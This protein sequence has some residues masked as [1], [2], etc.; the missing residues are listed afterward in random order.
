VLQIGAGA[1]GLVQRAQA[2]GILEGKDQVTPVPSL[3]SL[4]TTVAVK[5]VKPAA[6]KTVLQALMSELKVLSHL[7]RHQNIVNLLGAVTDR[8]PLRE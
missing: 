5:S 7:G 2:V 6:G 4:Q 3:H 8:L 1:F